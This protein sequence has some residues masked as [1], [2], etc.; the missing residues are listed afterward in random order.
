MKTSKMRRRWMYLS[1]AGVFIL[2]L[3]MPIST[4]AADPQTC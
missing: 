2:A 4:V 3:S 1:L